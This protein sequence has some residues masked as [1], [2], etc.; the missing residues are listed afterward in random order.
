MDEG[1]VRAKKQ[2]TYIYIYTHQID[3]CSENENDKV[4]KNT[5]TCTHSEGRRYENKLRRKIASE[6][7][8]AADERQRK[9]ASKRKRERTHY[10]Y[11]TS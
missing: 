3:N 6:T 1:G 2:R 10:P 11:Q 4:S 9:R 5:G 8:K 7:K